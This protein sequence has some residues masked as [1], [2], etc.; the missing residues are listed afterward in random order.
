M[1]RIPILMYHHVASVPAGN[2]Q[3]RDLYVPSHAFARQM[4]LLKLLGYQGMSMSDAMPYLRGEKTGKVAVITMDDGYPDNLSNAL[5]ALHKHGFNATCYA[6][7]SA[8][9][10]TNDWD[11]DSSLAIRETLMS[12]EQ[13]LQW[14]AAGMEIG[15]HTRT[16]PRLTQCSDAE[17]HDEIYLCKAELE[18]RLG[19]EVSQFC[20][21]YGDHDDRVADA[22]R[23][24]G[25][26]DAT[27]TIRGHAQ[28]GGDPMRWPR[29]A[30]RLRDKLPKILM[31]LSSGYEDRHG[32]RQLR[33][34]RTAQSQ[35]PS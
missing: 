30:I 2:Q 17:L 6:V 8:P 28:P 4:Q 22:V 7:S 21:P 32:R 15:A 3:L 5:P 20:Y 12:T 26:A 18:N 16:H 35:P 25:F 19:T 1:A 14:Q 24:A 29:M 9:G 11:A 23:S 13:L 34:R 10:N 27:T 33:K 31:R